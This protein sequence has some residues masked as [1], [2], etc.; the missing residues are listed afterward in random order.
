MGKNPEDRDTAKIAA[1]LTQGFANS[2]LAGLMFTHA[3][4]ELLPK[5]SE[6]NAIN[7]GETAGGNGNRRTP[8]GQVIQPQQGTPQ[9]VP[10]PAPRVRVE[11]EAP[12]APQRAPSPQPATPG[13]NAGE[14][15]FTPLTGEE[16][17]D[18]IINRVSAMGGDEFAQLGQGGFNRINL[19]LGEKLRGN[20][21][22]I[23]SLEDALK[24][25]N[26]ELAKAKSELGDNPT[27][28]QI[29]NY[30]NLSA[31]PQ[32]FNEAL[33]IAKTEK[34]SAPPSEPPPVEA[35]KPP[36]LPP[37]PKPA[38]PSAPVASE[39]P[40][41]PFQELSEKEKAKQLASA[42]RMVEERYRFASPE[43]LAQKLA[44]FDKQSPQPVVEA[45]KKGN[46]KCAGW[47]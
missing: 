22:G 1:L 47:K 20:A 32:F 30:V 14:V 35:S 25:A 44:E 10:Q 45:T 34:P 17:P 43:I 16:A 40:N 24:K 6:K 27:E 33:T 5:G 19:P 11:G 15:T 37:E 26:D 3:A 18:E 36:L 8:P 28:Q 23:A 9:N 46:Q 31:K 29:Q 41:Q 12:P 4:S 39:R 2:S 42:R 38:A 13:E 7:I 21:D